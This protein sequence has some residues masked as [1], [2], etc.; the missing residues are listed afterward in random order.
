ML[1]ILKQSTDFFV[2]LFENEEGRRGHA[3]YYLPKVEI[4]INVMINGREASDH[5]VNNDIRKLSI[6]E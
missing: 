5:P 6:E 1:Q 3:E 4:M 2:L